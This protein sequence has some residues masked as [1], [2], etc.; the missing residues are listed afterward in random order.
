MEGEELEIFE[1]AQ[2]R[3]NSKYLAEAK[4]IVDISYPSIL[5]FGS[6][7]LS[8]GSWGYIAYEDSKVSEDSPLHQ[9]PVPFLKWT[10]LLLLPDIL[11]LFASAVSPSLTAHI[12]PS[13]QDAFPKA[14]CHWS[15]LQ[16]PE[17]KT[18]HLFIALSSQKVT[19]FQTMECFSQS[20]IRQS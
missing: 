7:V 1:P 6:F 16:C 20:L 8:P 15:L 9:V 2:K 5:L 18:S 4:Q 10:L 3:E 14:T 13:P 11:P 19:V 12:L 17:L